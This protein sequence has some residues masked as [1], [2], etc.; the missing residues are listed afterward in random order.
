MFDEAEHFPN[1][2]FKMWIMLKC[3]QHLVVNPFKMKLHYGGDITFV[4]GKDYW[5]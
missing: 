1:Y 3:N 4:L 5:L 2:Y